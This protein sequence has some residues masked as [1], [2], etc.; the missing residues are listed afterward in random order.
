M[1]T[2]FVDSHRVAYTKSLEDHYTRQSTGEQR[3]RFPPKYKAL[4]RKTEAV[5]AMRIRA[6]LVISGL[7][8]EI[9]VRNFHQ[10]IRIR[11]Q[12]LLMK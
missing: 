7:F 5:L 3:V 1:I 9:R 2:F 10:Q 4:N 11:I 6:D 12:P 8:C